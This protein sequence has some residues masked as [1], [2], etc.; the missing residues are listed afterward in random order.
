MDVT[1][2]TDLKEMVF[3]NSAL[4]ALP[5]LEDILGINEKYTADK[6]FLEMVKNALKEFEQ[7]CPLILEMKVTRDQL[8]SERAMPGFGEFRSN[9]TMYL[10]GK[11]SEDQIILVPN[12]IPQWR[13]G[14]Y[15]SYASSYPGPGAYNFF[16]E[17]RR[18]YVFIDDLPCQ[19]MFIVKALCNRPIIPDFLPDGSFNP[20]SEKAG[21]YW[22][23]PDEGIDTDYFQDI[24]LSN[25]LDYIRNLKSSVMLPNL[26]VDIFSNVDSA[27]QEL[28]GRIDQYQAQSGWR[29]QLLY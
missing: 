12:A 29:G 3:I 5:S 6:I 25:V 13:T 20:E 22:M 17:Y 10:D 7:D 4:I 18:P 8:R 1:K 27:Y 23:H 15:S 28:R 24:L 16:T 9:F 14:S 11:I 21:V 19:D 26:G 2:L